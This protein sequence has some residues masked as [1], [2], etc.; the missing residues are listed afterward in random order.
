MRLA[1]LLEPIKRAN[2]PLAFFFFFFFFLPELGHYGFDYAKVI[3]K[4]LA[5][6]R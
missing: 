3:Q 1:G 4:R 6:Q 2:I 5:K